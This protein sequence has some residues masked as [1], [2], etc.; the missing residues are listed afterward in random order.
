ML[1]NSNKITFAIETTILYHFT[2][3]EHDKLLKKA[4]TPK[5]K[6]FIKKLKDKINNEGKN[7]LTEKDVVKKVHIN[8]ERK[9]F[10]TMREHK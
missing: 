3:E 5:F 6:K 2:E 9:F 8:C 1:R 10:M 4:V 7:I